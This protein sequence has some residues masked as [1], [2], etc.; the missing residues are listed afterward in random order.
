MARKTREQFARII[1]REF[2]KTAE[3]QATASVV[4]DMSEDEVIRCYTQRDLYVRLRQ[5]QR[6]NQDGNPATIRMRM[7][8]CWG[9]EG[10]A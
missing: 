1:E 10:R 8:R 3:I 6:D 9:D 4:V 2:L 5:L 7:R